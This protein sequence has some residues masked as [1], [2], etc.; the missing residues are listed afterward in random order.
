MESRSEARTQWAARQ[1][2]RLPALDPP[3][4]RGWEQKERAFH[5]HPSAPARSQLS[6]EITTKVSRPGRPGLPTQGTPHPHSHLS[7]RCTQNPV[8]VGEYRNAAPPPR[9]V[10]T[11]CYKETRWLLILRWLHD[12]SLALPAGHPQTRTSG[13]S[14]S[15]QFIA[16]RLDLLSIRREDHEL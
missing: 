8:T 7:A 11:L 2:L 3:S 4:S 5:E 6:E 9:Y 14:L 15:S 12:R 10:S 13:Q 16:K 1:V